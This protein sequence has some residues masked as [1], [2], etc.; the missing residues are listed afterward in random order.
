M[1]DYG[2]ASV[3]ID[4]AKLKS[5]LRLRRQAGKEKFASSVRS[6]R[7]GDRHGTHPA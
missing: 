3:G 2:Q 4:L 6:T 1:A 7:V 5:A